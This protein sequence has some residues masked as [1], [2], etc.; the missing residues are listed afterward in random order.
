MHDKSYPA[1]A[2]AAY[3]RTR[4]GSTAP[5]SLS[6]TSQAGHFAE[7]AFGAVCSC[8]RTL[9]VYRV[10]PGGGL[11]RLKRWPKALERRLSCPGPTLANT[12]ASRAAQAALSQEDDR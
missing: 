5:T 12:A 6:M 10:R 2:L 8:S 7:R 4:H 1:R 3:Y 11:S 9:A